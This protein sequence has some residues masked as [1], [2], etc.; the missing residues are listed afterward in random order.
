MT[1]GTENELNTETVSNITIPLSFFSSFLS[2]SLNA[3][4]E[5]W[6]IGAK[7][8]KKDTKEEGKELLVEQ[9]IEERNERLG[10]D[11]YTEYHVLETPNHLHLYLTAHKMCWHFQFEC[12]KTNTDTV[13]LTK[14]R[15]KEELHFSRSQRTQY[16][17]PCVDSGDTGA[18]GGIQISKEFQ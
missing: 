2:H 4:R 13:S 7:L 14:T 12:S 9:H 8:T 10:M 11:T 16:T 17:G 3:K 1:I 6:K 18:D 15:I 5:K